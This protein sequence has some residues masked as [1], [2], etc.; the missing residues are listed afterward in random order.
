M[1]EQYLYSF[2]TVNYIYATF[3]RT[4]LKH[5][6]PHLHAQQSVKM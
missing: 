1:H 4:A 5:F 2:E 6:Q 3:F